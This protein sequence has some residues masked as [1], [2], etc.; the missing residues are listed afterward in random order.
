M[1][2]AIT[3]RVS[4]TLYSTYV[5]DLRYSARLEQLLIHIG[6]CSSPRSTGVNSCPRTY[7]VDTLFVI[8]NNCN[9]LSC[10]AFPASYERHMTFQQRRLRRRRSRHEE[11]VLLILVTFARNI[12]G[13]ALEMSK[14]PSCIISLCMY[15]SWAGANPFKE[16]SNSAVKLSG[17]QSM[18]THCTIS[19]SYPLLVIWLFF[20]WS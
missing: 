2:F 10:H 14:Q 15:L 20:D 5:G 16:T 19:E 6:N 8:A 17:I 9:C 3:D 18:A 13:I 12:R 11:H 1:L 4:T 7:H